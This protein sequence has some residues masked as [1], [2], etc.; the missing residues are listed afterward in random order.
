MGNSI[1]VEAIA[2][3]TG[4]SQ[5]VTYSGQDVGSVWTK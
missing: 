2:V 4:N 3:L 5:N 1:F